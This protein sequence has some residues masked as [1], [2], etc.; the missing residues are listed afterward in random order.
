M[1]DPAPFIQ[2]L[3]SLLEEESAPEGGARRAVWI[4]HEECRAKGW[5]NGTFTVLD[6]QLFEKDVLPKFYK[7]SNFTSFV[8]QINHYGF[9]KVDA[10]SWTWAHPSGNFARDKA[11]ALYL[12][13]RTPSVR[14][15]KAIDAP[16]R[17]P[18][19]VEF[20]SYNSYEDAASPA[21]PGAASSGVPM[22]EL[23]RDHALVKQELIR[24]RKQQE[25]MINVV[26]DLVKCV[27]TAQQK[28]AVV[29]SKLERTLRFLEMAFDNG[30]GANGAWPNQTHVAEWMRLNGNKRMRPT[31]ALQDGKPAAGDEPTL[32]WLPPSGMLT[33]VAQDPPPLSPTLQS[34][35]AATQAMSL[36]AP[37]TDSLAA[38]QS[39]AVQSAQRGVTDLYASSTPVEGLG[40]PTS[41]NLDAGRD[42]SPI[43]AGLAVAESDLASLPRLQSLD[44]DASDVSPREID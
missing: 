16:P 19:A 7:H 15:R 10:E 25:R 31:L 3:H 30:A 5:P 23:A 1:N 11:S 37:G 2:K 9:K 18:P 6:N 38:S 17:Q 29:E 39:A 4:D 36:D 26:E 28:Q 33:S 32:Q 43:I 21:A 40:S 35:A 27:T 14:K 42:G 44:I 12:I 41:V 22:Q 34:I 8:R 13:K 24:V 20:G